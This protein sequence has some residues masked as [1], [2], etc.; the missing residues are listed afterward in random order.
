MTKTPQLRIAVIPY[1]NLQ[2]R[3]C[4][5]AGEGYGENLS[6]LMSAT[7]IHKLL[8]LCANVGFTHVKFTGGEPLLRKDIEAIVA[9]TRQIHGIREIQMVTNGTLLASRAESL[10]EAGLDFLTVSID[11]AEP[12]AFRE[13]RGGD[14]NLVIQGLQACRAVGLLVRINAVLFRRNFNQVEPLMELAERAGASLKLLDLIDLQIPGSHD[15]F[16]RE[17]LHFDRVHKFL[18]ER[19]GRVVGLEEAPGGVGAPLTDYLMPSGLHVLLKDATMGTYYH[20]SCHECR[21]YPCQDALISLRVTHDGYL[22]QCL[23]RN[24]NL[25]DVLAP[26]RT[27][28]LDRV[29]ELVRESFNILTGSTYEP[30]RWKPNVELVI[31]ELENARAGVQ[32]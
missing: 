18:E 25:V 15:F 23:I 24:D 20:E 7:E 9:D 12:K 3:Y 27:G 22:K 28:K 16:R 19:G 14:L 8:V 26:L 4:H 1:C 6:E 30:H 2:C 13:I 31:T 21:N 29:R 5:P 17:F 32:R 10:R 11:A